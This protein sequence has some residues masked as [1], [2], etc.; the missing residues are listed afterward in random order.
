MGK[1]QDVLLLKLHGLAIPLTNKKVKPVVSHVDV[2]LGSAIQEPPHSEMEVVGKVPSTATS[3]T[4][5][6]ES[7]AQQRL[8]VMVARAVVQP[9][10]NEV[11][12]RLLNW[13]DTSVSIPKGTVVATM[14][15]L[16]DEP[17]A[18]IATMGDRDQDVP[19]DVQDRLWK[20]A[21]NTGS[22][23]T[24]EQKNELCAVLL[25]YQD[26]FA[27]GPTDFGRTGKIQHDIDTGAARPIRQQ[28]RRIPPIKRD[29]A[30]HLLQEMLE[31]DVIQAALGH[32]Q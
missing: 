14:E 24:A 6:M 29:E 25:E 31:K 1:T 5:I 27:R 7:N 21:E 28:V 20:L 2:V 19:S 32:R 4:W 18:D 26:L 10:G 30:K 16:P 11:P 12:I 13:K 3:K 9:P 17:L 23:L 22:H 8:P 15:L